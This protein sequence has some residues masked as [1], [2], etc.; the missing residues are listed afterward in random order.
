MT[1]LFEERSALAGI[2]WDGEE[3]AMGTAWIDYNDDGLLDLWVSP[4]PYQ[5]LP[6][7]YENQGD[8]TFVDVLP[9]IWVQRNGDAHGSSWADFDNDGDLD[10]AVVAGGGSGSGASPSFLFVNDNGTFQDRSTEFN[11][12]FSERRGRMPAWV[13]WNLDG[14]LDLIQVTAARPDRKGFTSL[15]EQTPDGS[16]VEVNDKAGFDIDVSA[17]SAQVS[18]LFGDGKSDIIIIGGEGDADSP[19]KVYETGGPVL[20]DITA[21]FP[22]VD[23]MEDAAIADFNNDLVP[24]IFMV[25]AGNPYYGEQLFQGSPNLLYARLRTR[26]DRGAEQ[27]FSFQTEGQASF[28]VDYPLSQIYIGA[29]KV[30]PTEEYFSLSPDNPETIGVPDRDLSEEGMYIGYDPDSET[31]EVFYVNPSAQLERTSLVVETENELQNLTPINLTQPDLLQKEATPGLLMYDSDTGQYI[32]QTELAGLSDPLSAQSVVAGDFDNDMDV[33]LYISST[34]LFVPLESIYYENQGDGTFVKIADAAGAA[35]TPIGPRYEDFGSGLNLAMGDYDAD[36]FLDIYMGNS[37]LRRKR[38]G[39]SGSSDSSS[40][41]SDSTCNCMICAACLDTS[42][43]SRVVRSGRNYLGSPHQLFRNKG[44]DNHWLQIDLEGVVS[45][46]DAIG[47]KVYVTAG[48]VT[49]LR[50]QNNGMH[51]YGQNMTRLHFGLAQNTQVDKIEIH[52]PS[53]IIQEIHDVAADQ[54]LDIVEELV[55]GTAEDDSLSGTSGDDL[56]RGFGGNDLLEG[57]EGDDTLEGGLGDDQLQGQDDDDQLFGNEGADTL[58][59]GLGNDLLQGQD[60]DDQLFGNEG[61]DT[62]EGGL[63]NDLLQGQN[64]DDQLFGNEGADTLQGGINKDLLKRNS[65]NELLKGQN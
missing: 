56:I 33:D 50:E 61:A 51:R 39:N 63:G 15:F 43:L 24:D 8:G 26:Q 40:G 13:D 45:N 52:W 53:G 32:D 48:G 16:F 49:Q 18:D 41:S 7:L 62:L 57:Q 20:N 28:D 46:R 44:N 58:E 27:G 1:I 14:R 6:K 4:H 3:G 30:N 37:V 54:I 59:G 29:N 35:G 23:D 38:S 34:S 64:D 25:G 47:A 36:G 10:V 60:D 55:D 12:E 2:T 42:D 11:T 21:S 65:A 17:G 19:V 22:Q 31:W 5:N 9:D